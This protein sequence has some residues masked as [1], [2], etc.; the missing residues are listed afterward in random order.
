[1]PS[2]S[3]AFT[4]IEVLVSLA[5]FAGAAVVLGATYVNVM[6]SYDAVARRNEHE[7]DLAFLR[8]AVLGE[9][10]RKTVELG[11]DT[12]L[13]QNRSAHWEAKVEE[14]KLGDLFRVSFHCEIHDPARVQPWVHDETFM[15]LRPTWSDPTTRDQLR[16][17]SRDRLTKGGSQ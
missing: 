16:A 4:L 17:D 8:E 2:R 3:K 5:I 11:G 7:Q 15:L 6:G 13:P 10:D 12:A 9:P 14:A 1:M